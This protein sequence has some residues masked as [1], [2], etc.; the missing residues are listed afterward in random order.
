[1]GPIGPIGLIGPIGFIDAHALAR[2]RDLT[3]PV[4]RAAMTCQAHQR[5]ISNC[6]DVT[7][8]EGWQ[9]GSSVVVLMTNEDMGPH[10]PRLGDDLPSGQ[11]PASCMKP[12][13]GRVRSLTGVGSPDTYRYHQ[14]PPPLPM[15]A[16]RQRPW[17]R[18]DGP[19][20]RREPSLARL[21]ARSCCRKRSP[22]AGQYSLG[23]SP[24][25]R[26]QEP[27]RKR[28]RNWVL[29]GSACAP[30]AFRSRACF[31]SRVRG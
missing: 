5:G 9:S 29:T 8:E 16:R 21:R 20:P 15:R 30:P 28:R 3:W 17:P 1:M 25:D 24:G 11:G 26:P 7:Y 27:S 18:P 22:P 2:G 12:A 4:G 19:P 10:F 6:S 23:Q 13:P 31:W 14:Q